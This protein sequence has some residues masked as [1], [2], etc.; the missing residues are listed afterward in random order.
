ALRPIRPVA[1]YATHGA[2]RDVRRFDVQ[3]EGARPLESVTTLE[4]PA[5]VAGEATHLRDITSQQW[6]S[7][8][9]AWL[10]WLFDGLD[11]HLYTLVATP[12]VAQPLAATST[13]HPGGREERAHL[14]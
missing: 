14:R 2:R 6:R 13:A 3:V 12:L 1:S 5:H 9:A 4:P 11:M 7:G 10:G 8:T